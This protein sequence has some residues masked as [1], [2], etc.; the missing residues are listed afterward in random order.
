METRTKPTDA[1]A[2]SFF[3]LAGWEAATR[4]NAAAFDWMT[5][6]WQQWLSLMATLPQN[7]ALSAKATPQARTIEE[8][9]A[10]QAEPKR[11]PRVRATAKSPAGAKARRSRG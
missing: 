2:P 9:P 8:R 1:G 3:P 10:A 4:W 6:G 11:S 5:R 7:A